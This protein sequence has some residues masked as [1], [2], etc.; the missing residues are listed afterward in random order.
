MSKEHR[1]PSV[2]GRR[3]VYILHSDSMAFWDQAYG[4]A[5]AIGT[6]FAYANTY[7]DGL[8]QHEPTRAVSCNNPALMADY[9]V[10][11]AAYALEG[12]SNED[13]SDLLCWP[14]PPSRERILFAL[15]VKYKPG[16]QR[17][18]FDPS[19]RKVSSRES[20]KHDKRWHE[21]TEYHDG[22][23]DGAMRVLQA[24]EGR[25]AYR[26]ML[27]TWVTINAVTQVVREDHWIEGPEKALFG[28]GDHV[29]CARA[30]EIAGHTFASLRQRREA[31]RMLWIH[32]GAIKRDRREAEATSDCVGHER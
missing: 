30:F 4:T 25:G 5:G 22:T 2:E 32:R 27:E 14:E 10:S 21:I 31:E 8:T 19:Q 7:G 15:S 28:E 17:R 6:H 18:Y 12:V 29:A 26:W 20:L 1:F 9:L 16:G 3:L 11:L 24:S 13:Q 23:V